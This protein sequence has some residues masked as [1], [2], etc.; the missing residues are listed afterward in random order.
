MEKI[1]YAVGQLVCDVLG[2]LMRECQ[3]GPSV[4]S[5]GYATIALLLGACGIAIFLRQ[6]N[7]RS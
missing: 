5:I 7:S 4:V 2:S 3:S 6:P 1:G